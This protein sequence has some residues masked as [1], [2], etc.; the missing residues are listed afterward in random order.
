MEFRKDSGNRCFADPRNRL[1]EIPLRCKVWVV[2]YVRGDLFLE[3]PNLLVQVSNMVVERRSDALMGNID[4][5]HLLG[6]HTD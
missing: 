2:C 1:K 4:A 6:F 3:T 5:V